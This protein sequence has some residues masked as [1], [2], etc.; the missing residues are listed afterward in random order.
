MFKSKHNLKFEAGTWPWNMLF[1]GPPSY[2]FRVG[3]CNGLFSSTRE[4]YIII[5]IDN[6]KKG[7]G[8]FEDVLEWFY[9]SCKRDKM[10]LI[11]AEIM[12]ERFYRHLIHKRGFTDTTLHKSDGIN[13]VRSYKEMP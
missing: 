3:T 13:V 10:D 2:R 6:N 11:F 12:N 7:N 4:A 5:A 8:H 9:E 1:E